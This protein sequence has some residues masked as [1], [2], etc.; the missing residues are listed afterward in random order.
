MAEENAP[1]DEALAARLV[2]ERF[3]DWAGLPIRR[4]PSD[5]TDNAL[6][7]LGDDKC[8]RLPSTPY[9]PAQLRKEALWLPAFQALPLEVPNPIAVM[10]PS[11]T[12][13][14]PWAVYSWLE[15]EPVSASGLSDMMAAAEALGGFVKALRA[16]DAADAPPAGSDNHYRGVA[17]AGRDRVTRQSFD[18]IADLFPLSGLEAAWAAA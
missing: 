17:L 12:F 4:V 9:S 16:V 7:R 6:F 5:G 2:A 3:P 18:G 13:P 1:L 15:G 11:E 8:V 10:E 14:H